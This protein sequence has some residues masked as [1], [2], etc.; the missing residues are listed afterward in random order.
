MRYGLQQRSGIRVTKSHAVAMFL[1]LFII[2][3]H[4]YITGRQLRISTCFVFLLRLDDTHTNRHSFK[5]ILIFE[6]SE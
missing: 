4:R 2:H 6:A 3:R 5:F 1:L